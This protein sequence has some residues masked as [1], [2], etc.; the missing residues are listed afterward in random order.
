MHNNG[1]K[2]IIIGLSTVKHF[3]SAVTE[4]QF[5]LSKVINLV[6]HLTTAQI[7]TFSPAVI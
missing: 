4:N 5:F 1:L 2:I 3:P 6:K 7:K